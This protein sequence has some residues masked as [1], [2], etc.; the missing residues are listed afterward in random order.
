MNKLFYLWSIILILLQLSFVFPQPYY[1]NKTENN[2]FIENKGQWNQEIKYLA[3][4]NGLN[5][6]IT[7]NG[8]VYDFYNIEKSNVISKENKLLDSK[9]ESLSDDILQ[10]TFTGQ[11]VQMVFEGQLCNAIYEPCNKQDTYY[12]FFCSNDK[13]KWI[14]YI[15]VYREVVVKNI[16]RGIDNRYYFDNGRIRYDI[17]INAGADLSQIKMLYKGHSGMRNNDKG[18]LVFETCL[19]NIEQKNIYAYQEINGLKQQVECKF[20]FNY[21]ETIGFVIKNYDSSLALVIDPLIWSTYIGGKDYD[22]ARAI[23]IDSS[24]NVIVSGYT[25]SNDFPTT[26]G[27]YERIQRYKDLYVSK[28][29]SFGS[30]LIFSTLIGGSDQD[31]LRAMKIDDQMDIYL[32]GIT[33]SNDYPCTSEA[34]KNTYEPSG[35]AFITKLNKFGNDL[36]YSSYFG[37][38]CSAAAL[39]IDSNKNVYI[40]GQEHVINFPT[41]EGAF[42]RNTK[43]LNDGFV[44]KFNLETP[45]II[46]STLLGGDRSEYIND[47]AVNNQG[48]AYVIGETTS[49]NYPT[50]SDSYCREK[51]NGTGKMDVFVS[52]LNSG[53]TDII[54]STYFGGNENEW[55]KSLVL[56]D[57]NNVIIAG[58]TLS[59]NLPTSNNAYCRYRKGSNGY[60]CFITKFNTNLSKYHF[61]T[62]YGGDAGEVN[63][64]NMDYIDK[65]KSNIV[66]DKFRNV[67][68]CGVTSSKN[69]PITNDA[70]QTTYSFLPDAFIA[71]INSDGSD[72]LYG[73][74]YGGG[75][76]DIFTGLAIDKLGNVYLCGDTESKDLQTTTGA[77]DESYNYGFG[78]GFVV[79]IK[80]SIDTLTPSIIITNPKSGEEYKCGE[81]NCIIKWNAKNIEK[82]NIYYSYNNQQWINIADDIDASV[83]LYTEWVIPFNLSCNYQIKIIDS[84]NLNNF[85]VSADFCIIDKIDFQPN[86]DG[87]R[88]NNSE[89]NIWPHSWWES[90]R[91]NEPYD[92]IIFKFYAGYLSGE[93]IPP[94]I[95]PDWNLFVNAFGSDYAYF[96]NRWFNPFAIW[97]WK[98]ISDVWGGSCY[99]FTNSSLLYYSN[100]LQLPDNIIHTYDIPI[101]GESRTTINKYFLY[102]FSSEFSNHFRDVYKYTPNQT[103]EALKTSFTN[104]KSHNCGLNYY[105]KNGNGKDCGHSVVPYKIS[106]GIDIQSSHQIDSVF[107]YDN[108]YP[109]DFNQCILV[110]VDDNSWKNNK[111][112][113]EKGGLFIPD[114]DIEKYSIPIHPGIKAGVVIKN[115]L[116]NNILSETN[117][118]DIYFNPSSDVVL[119]NSNNEQINN[120]SLNNTNIPGAIP[121]FPITGSESLIIGYNIPNSNN[122]ISITYKP[123]STINNYLTVLGEN[124]G[125]CSN[126]ITNSTN[127]FQKFYIDQSNDSVSIYSPFLINKFDV[128][129]VFQGSKVVNLINCTLKPDDILNFKFINNAKNFIIYNPNSLKTYYLSLNNFGNKFDSISFERLQINRN[130]T[131]EIIVNNWENMQMNA[132][133]SNEIYLRVYL[134]T[135]VNPSAIIKDSCLNCVQTGVNENEN[136]PTTTFKVSPNPTSNKILIKYD[137][138][139]QGYISMYLI[140]ELGL[141]VA[142]LIDNKFVGSGEHNLTVDVSNLQTGIYFCIIKNGNQFSIEKIIIIK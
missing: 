88:F 69:L 123:E 133:Q 75:G 68:I 5:Y 66:I 40:A 21:D 65:W 62:F 127:D 105:W 109:N 11:V 139:N 2:Y 22:F 124:I 32:T 17:I 73:S 91:S 98:R 100:Y 137:L 142:K 59:D 112:P 36:I 13:S 16:Y 53:G 67:Y 96:L 71:K 104:D 113:E 115:N 85:G 90:I 35:D 63:G 102:Q 47:I 130:E 7:T 84:K 24:Q 117:F 55:G 30:E 61:S 20:K 27:A 118:Y 39:A 50:S 141:E 94:E 4:L 29:N 134:G 86:P 51:I 81:K 37:H 93:S 18:E 110:D 9:S 14:S 106:R 99:G 82:V 56:D 76:L 114:I 79:K 107:I 72:L 3:K 49:E 122:K 119:T 120:S 138:Y 26:V 28:L 83:G 101:N 103:V 57:S 125:F 64:E 1:N 95:F 129:L 108:R 58:Y 12:N 121:I 111:N 8:V 126:F 132:T 70:F 92:D 78:D 6:W 54:S 135:S 140:N 131:H 19:G 128:S 52:I 48:N 46:Y 44:A 80:L 41:T 43:G 60:D 45:E 38:G 42:S 23:C 87:F 33:Y 77:F 31:Y 15:P 89:E 116:Y 25:N 10:E 74:Y 136:K 34:L 97:K